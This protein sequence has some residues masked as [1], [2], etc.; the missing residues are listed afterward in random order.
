VNIFTSAFKSALPDSDE[1]IR[2]ELFSVERLEQYAE[3]LAASQSVTKGLKGRP[4][5]P[6]VL[7]NGRVLRKSY[8]ALA[9]AIEQDH[10]I[11]PAAE[12]LVDN[13]HVVDEQLRQIRNDL[14][15][16]YYRILPKLASGDLRG[17]PRVFGIAWAFVAHMDSRFDGDVLRAFV[18]AYQ[19]VQP[20]TIGELWALTITLRIVLIE[21]LR[22]LSERLIQSRVARHEADA[23]A[24]SILGG[25]GSPAMDPSDVLRSFEKAPLTTA[26]AVQLV[27]RLRDLDSKVA[28]VL[29][30]LDHRL[31]EQGTTADEIVR[32][33]HQQQSAA[34]ITVRSIITSMR[35]ITAFDW[36]S[37]FETV[38]R[39]DDILRNATDFAELDF[40]TRD[41]YRQAIEDLSRHS[42]RSELEIAERV[43]EK[44]QQA[45]VERS[46]IS[47]SHNGMG[48][49][50]ER[51]VEPGY[52]LVS[53]GR[54]AFERE[55]AYRARWKRRLMRLY[56][57]A[58]TPGYLGTIAA[59]TALILAFPLHHTHALG[60]PLYILVLL[61]VVAAIPASDLA[62][63][64]VNRAVTEILGPRKLPRLALRGGIPANLRTMVVMPTLLTTAA[65]IDE[66]LERLEVHY[67]ANADGEIYFA[68]LSDWTDAPEE[69]LAGDD[70]LLA[71]A[72]A[73]IA[74][75]NAK[76]GPAA[77]GKRFSIFHRR[78]VWNASERKWIGW[79]RKRGKLKELNRLLRGA[80][81][82][83]F[84]T[85]AGHVPEIPADVRYVI[86]LDA[87]TRLPRDAARRLVG[88]IAHPLNQARFDAQVGRVV[89]GYGVVQ[90]RITPSLPAEREGSLFQEVFSGPCGV[91]PYT[92]AVSDV[93]QDLF[94]E[95]SFTGK[96]IYDVDAFE[97]AL[98][99]KVPENAMLSHDL[100]EGIFARTA[101]A[102]DIEFFEEF[103]SDYEVAA[104]RHHRWARGDWQLLP[105]IFSGRHP[106][107]KRRRPVAIPAIGR[108]KMLDNLRR[109]LS[110]PAAFLTMVAGWLLLPSSP[111]LWPGLVVVSIA[112]PP[113]MPVLSDLNLPIR[114]M[115]LRL[116]LRGVLTDLTLGACQIGLTI[117]FLA[118][119]AWLMSDAIARTLVR[120]FITHRNLL[121]WVT[122]AQAKRRTKSELLGMYRLMY[123]SVLLAAALVAALAIGHRHI[124]L[125][126]G[127]F[128][129][130]WFVAPAVARWVSLPRRAATE[131][132]IRP[133]DRRA[134]RLIARRTWRF[135]EAFVT[136]A[137][138]SLPPDGFQE[139]PA[140]VIAYRTSPTNMG[141]YLLATIS[142][143]DFGWLGTWDTVERLEAT[144]ANMA[145]MELYRGHF[146]NWYDTTDLRPLEPRYISS[147]DSG[148][149]AGDLI[150]V[151]NACRELL[152]KPFA[153]ARLLSGMDDA[154]RLAREALDAAPGLQRPRAART[155]HLSNALDA[156][157]N[158]LNRLPENAVQW[159]ARFVEL[160][161]HVNAL[162]GIVHNLAQERGEVAANELAI[163]ADA[164]KSNLESQ[165]RDAEI[166]FPAIRLRESEMAASGAV[167]GGRLLEQMTSGILSKPAPNLANAAEYFEVALRD[168]DEQRQGLADSAERHTVAA[169]LEVLM[170]AVT[171]SAAKAASLATRIS[172]LV[173]TAEAI[174][175]AMDFTFLY[176]KTRRLFSIGYRLSDQ[177]LDADCYDLLASESRLMSFVAIAKGDVPASHWFRLGRAVTPVG[178]GAALISWS[179]SMFEYLMP[180][181]VMQ[182]PANSLLRQT[183]E[184]IVRRQIAYGDER[185]VPWG[186]SESAYNERDLNLTYQYSSF[187]VPG[188]GLKRGLADDVVVAPYATALAAMFDVPDALRNFLRIQQIGGL[189]AYGF[190]EAVD[191][192]ASRVPEGQD[193]AIVRAY[194]AHHQGMA[195]VAFS[196]IITG[197]AM[198]A[199]FH[200]A[201]IVQ[202]TELL[203]QE[204]TPREVLVARPNPED[205]AAAT[206]VRELMPPVIRQ[207]ATPHDSPPR[208]HL[209]S[210]GR[211]SVM[212]TA[213]GS[214]YS[215]WRDIAVTRWRE[216]STC[217]RW[218]YYIYL[219]D[220][221]SGKM[222]SAGYQ[223]T[224]AEPD[225]YQV[226][227]YEDRAE[228]MRRD[229]ALSTTLEIA[230]SAEDDTEMRRISVSNLGGSTREVE[231]TS[232]VE[233][234]IAPQAADVAHPA[235]SNLFVQTEFVS[236]V[237]ALLATRRRR[238][239]DE[240]AVW[241][242]HLAVAEDETASELQFET[243]RARFIG[244][245]RDA[246]SPVS[247]LSGQPL[248]GTVGSVLDPAMSLRRSV[249]I[250]PGGTTRIVFAM[251]AASSREQ[252][253][254][255]ADKYS[256]VGMIKRT[257]AMAWTQAQVQLYHLGISADE[258]NLFQRLANPL[259]FSD[260]A[261][262]PSSELL[263]RTNLQ[264][265]ALWKHGISGDLPIILVRIDGPEEVEIIRQLLR[266]H[267]YWRMKQFSADVVIINE[268]ASSYDQDL[269]HLL[270]S[271]VKTSQLRL[272]PESASVSGNIFL[273]R[274]DQISPEDNAILRSVARAVVLS[275]LGTLY[276]QINRAQRTEILAPP[277]RRAARAASYE[278]GPH[279]APDLEFFNGLGGFAENGRE[280]VVVLE[281][282][283]RTPEPWVNVIAN[284]SF[285]FLVSESGSGYTW[286]LN[287]HENQ[288]TPWSNDPVS[289]QPGEAIYIRDE[290]SGEVWTPTAAP[291]RDETAQYVARH[292]QGYSRFQHD[293]HG[294]AAELTQ[295]VPLQDSIKIS[296]LSLRNTSSRTRRLSVSAYA[297]W[298]L[299]SSRSASAPYI[300]TEIDPQTG[301]LFARSAWAGE[302]GGRIAFSDLS[303]KQTSWT[304][305]RGEFIGRN[306]TLSHPAALERA[307]ALSKKSGAGLD[308]CAVL[309]TLFELKPGARTE[310]VFFLG[311]AASR[312]EARTLIGRYRNVDLGIVF[313]DAVNQWNDVLDGVQV[314]TPEHSMDLLL[315]RWLLYQ[316]L[317]CRVWG[318]TAFYQASG[319][320]GFRDQ[321]QDV[322]ALCAAKR[323][324]AR[325]HLLLAASRQFVEG[326]VQHWWHPPSGRGVRTRIS[327]D[328]LWL[329]YV[330]AH[331]VEA[332][333]DT[334]V[335]DEAV[336]FLEGPELAAGQE[337]SYFQPDVS[338]V[339]ATLYEHCARALDR[340]LAVGSHGLPLM[341]TGDWND[342]MNRVG[343]EGKG[344]SVWLGWFLHTTLWEFAKI[345]NLRGEHTRAETWRLHV[346]ALKASLE[347][348]AWDGEWYRRA[349]YDDGSPLGSAANTE[350]RIDS[351]AQSWGV[352]TGA[353][354]PGR[355]ARSM[356]AVVVEL[357]RRP[358]NLVVLFAP[359]FDHAA[360]DPGYIK[361][362]P[363]GVRENG[364]QYT[365]GA[366]WTILAFAALGNGEKAAEVFG[367]LN[368]I[369][370]S[371][372]TT[373][374]QK[375]K[376]EPYVVAGDVYS[377]PPH[378]GGG[379]WTWYSGSAAW[380]YRAGLE[381]ILGFRVRGA[382]LFLDP[383]IPRKW[384]AYSIRF[385]YHSSAYRISVENPQGVNR[386]VVHTELDGKELA[387]PAAIPLVDDG[388]KHQVRIVLGEVARK[389]G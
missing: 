299:G 312:E 341:G 106:A 213:A 135:F 332:T 16:G 187:G 289:D 188:L 351:I 163:W 383:C 208:T 293:S 234:A 31:A 238:S 97:A 52:Y 98:A 102:T 71:A 221:R 291:I 349:F 35:S 76:Y 152:K 313:R 37:F 191:Y 79:E 67:L 309:Q 216:D 280:Y 320:F 24:D 258:A 325:E 271:L 164:L 335:L 105:W 232:F 39:V 279:P 112:I 159:A 362:Y 340:S 110:S 34:T 247:I 29:A 319:A 328:L 250:P 272:S 245:G 136:S 179:G 25:D 61:G 382:T 18:R 127:P 369:N 158:S 355:G 74:R 15:P 33:E 233:L 50:Q 260:P 296:R 224:G 38:S 54:Y 95:G 338:Q 343:R 252:A 297:E 389:E 243:D 6:R 330:V 281:K 132:P 329:P 140:P 3:N 267:E 87:D 138:H 206:H 307:G 275:R 331:F 270:D 27:Q 276:E 96:G 103:P 173:R 107:S 235:F 150:V 202:A 352:I 380:L 378:A 315:N 121:E 90:P 337:D 154:L 41:S 99:D 300:I 385:R 239:E 162:L 5:L 367:M 125:A 365:H 20:L 379:G 371:S 326:D 8:Q 230:V 181:L 284:P 12:W 53:A 295:F 249:R 192:T 311:Q 346:V 353:A 46:E 268:K 257:L 47:Q 375:Y 171:D 324:V 43:V 177:S 151:A 100:F 161:E 294:I 36:S 84:V 134:I 10:A 226:S 359:P 287:S 11:T 334:A 85:S 128:L 55:L 73:G 26:F 237:G 118:H 209:L 357:I 143:N 80:S 119:Q 172:G 356:A 82:T 146:Y 377:E 210:N 148:N 376:V 360:H 388:A 266:A 354:E 358:D 22:R 91:D 122:A 262:R 236:P 78:R 302:F 314:T 175:H 104:S 323:E 14:P 292:G 345:A 69:S 169:H 65:E 130:L 137:D 305:D 48:Q 246:T 387:G 116:R 108:W 384:P 81:D 56:V 207:F 184:L 304:C 129:V 372:S 223:P 220:V 256:G 308:P 153:G 348:E 196:N 204:R 273:L 278:A 203:L 40:A 333:G 30:W 66:H 248:S 168:L 277:A 253:L 189:G 219:R 32:A 310:I 298:V 242:A 368:P 28:P 19:R 185:G 241:V 290:L 167:S 123:G 240:T 1:P 344:E 62:V 227:F 205:V 124:W 42:D 68:L 72:A 21:N 363:P 195:L 144:L 255:L 147:V 88:A 301:A 285:G 93:Y 336:P 176:D 157:S 59:V 259:L 339:S 57:R 321:L 212:V 225:F 142:A 178:H 288:L 198:R 141:L 126:A 251:A 364:G 265:N 197:G 13:F 149:L 94:R 194:F 381:W 7:E 201:P 211:Y 86:T 361:G 217:D 101:L 75:L 327:D 282:D 113:L 165:A 200:A 133:E 70:E 386:G 60:V 170:Q 261:A 228:I 49:A 109:S 117:T 229:G 374:V 303:G 180:A 58:A 156:L 174:F 318:R 199:R 111:W 244:R 166:M 160:K 139:D 131:Q 114:G 263:T 215:R 370:R 322:M 145:R 186:I 182:T 316:T 83:T 45:R 183:S 120:L 347:R 190:Y 64:I 17:Y 77:A 115:S 317:S 63:A 89:E 306:G 9:R 366:A 92:S 350:C 342:G 222:W 269:Q 283:R 23:L 51:Y 2:A 373:G 193:F 44:T 214:G 274:A 155:K 264:I 254:N 4:L 286:S 231:I 218:G